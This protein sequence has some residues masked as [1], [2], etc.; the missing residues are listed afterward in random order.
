MQWIGLAAAI[1]GLIYLV[2][3]GLSAPEP[4]GALLMC[5]AGIAWGVYSIHGKG[6]SS[7]VTM[8]AGNFA[9][10][11]PMAIIASVIAYSA[12]HLE[13]YGHHAR[14]VI[15]SRNVWAGICPLVQGTPRPENYPGI[16]RTALGAGSSSLW[17]N[18]I[19]LGET[20]CE[21]DRHKRFDTRRGG[22]G[23]HKA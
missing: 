6:I 16:S 23:C 10:S 7:P 20:I 19:S 11:A 8:T 1:C 15:R 17:R 3:T 18:R 12:I 22:F 21:A 13:P 14:A 2:M 4:F 9:R 5:I